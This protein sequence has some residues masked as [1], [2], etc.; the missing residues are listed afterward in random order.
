MMPSNS[1]MVSSFDNRRRFLLR[2][3]GPTIE[4]TP[5]RKRCSFSRSS[6]ANGLRR[7]QT[8]LAMFGSPTRLFGKLARQGCQKV[9]VG[10]LIREENARIYFFLLT[11]TK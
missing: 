5:G 9:G 7:L 4:G 6:I 1:N 8:E 11:N 3:V 10:K 2:V